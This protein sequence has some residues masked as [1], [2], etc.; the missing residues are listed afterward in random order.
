[1]DSSS[2]HEDYMRRALA[3]GKKGLGRTSPNP[4]V[5]A[6]IVRD[7]AIIGRGFHKKAGTPHAE[8]NA[9]A[10]ARAYG[11]DLRGATMYVTLEPCNHS[12]R[13]P[14]CTEAILAA[15][16]RQVYIGTKDPNAQVAG[17]GAAFLAARGVEVYLDICR[18]ACRQLI[19]PFSKH[20]R[21]GM[22]WVLMKAGMSLDGKIT[23]T[24]GQSGTITGPEAAVYVHGLRNELDA[25]LIGVGT[26]L[27]DNPSLTT[28][29]ADHS[30]RD[31]V[32][33][34]LDSTLRL[35]PDCQML[36]QQS[37]SSTWIFCREDA[38]LAREAR[39]QGAGAR[40][41]RIGARP[42]GDPCLDLQQIMRYLG[43][44]GIASVL[45]EGGAQVH[46]SFLAEDLVDEVALLLAPYFIGEAGTPLLQGRG[47]CQV[48][49]RDG[50]S[51]AGGHHRKKLCKICTEHLGADLLY[52]GYFTDPDSLFPA[53]P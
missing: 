13:T 53:A 50:N 46:A 42:S 36:R 1:M 22:P 45:V 11:H 4:A 31:P 10:N 23:H 28:R 18:S 48:G 19:V 5:G 47:P 27:I 14:P 33:L 16:I 9:L 34:V 17:G 49:N 38:D 15:G 41:I 20:S 40:V 7:G 43:G 29:L 24:Q 32:R 52:R 26:A 30:G 25:I 2:R 21:S 37:T 3:E 8:V 6:V 51:G 35:S 12:G 39:L 44:Q